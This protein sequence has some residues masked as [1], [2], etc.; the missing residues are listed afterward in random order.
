MLSERTLNN[1]AVYM[2]MRGY[3]PNIIIECAVCPK[4][5][6]ANEGIAFPTRTQKGDIVMAAFCCAACYLAAMPVTAL[7]RA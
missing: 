3:Q 2:R 5:F 1:P 4:L 7:W 6:P